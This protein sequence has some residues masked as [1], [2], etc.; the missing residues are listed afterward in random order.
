MNYKNYTINL[1]YSDI[2][3]L[4]FR[5]PCKAEVVKTGGEVS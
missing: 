5:G 1:G 3:S 2:A 4:I